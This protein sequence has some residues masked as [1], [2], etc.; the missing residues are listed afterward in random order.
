[1]RTLVAKGVMKHGGPD[2]VYV[3]DLI[4]DA[5]A[6][7]IVYERDMGITEAAGVKIQ[8]LERHCNLITTARSLRSIRDTLD[9]GDLE[10]VKESGAV[11]SAA[12]VQCADQVLKAAAN[13]LHLE[14]EYKVALEVDYNLAMDV[15]AGINVS[16]IGQRSSEY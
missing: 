1:M 11:L 2:R 16:D 5:Q 6:A 15:A 9:H 10:E 8:E 7:N 3:E 14:A 4:A 13:I 12:T